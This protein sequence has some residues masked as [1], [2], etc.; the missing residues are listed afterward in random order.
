M[1]ATIEAAKGRA[2]V[3]AGIIVDSTRD[4]IR[5]CRRHRLRNRPPSAWRWRDWAL[6]GARA[7]RRS[8]FRCAKQR[9]DN[10][11]GDLA[12][13]FTGTRELLL[14]FRPGST[15][16]RAPIRNRNPR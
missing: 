14:S 12:G 7:R 6:W 5:R 8:K 15:A 3:I 2:P 13:G 9:R 16:M 1:A 4:A 11:A 10:D